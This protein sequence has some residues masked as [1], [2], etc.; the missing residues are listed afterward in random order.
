MR[1][2]AA[3][4]DLRAALSDEIRAAL[5][6]VSVE[7]VKPKAVHRCR[8]RLKRARALARVGR[9]CAPGLAAVFNESARAIMIS[10][11]QARDLA[12]L[13]ACARTTA[14]KAS[15]KQAAALTA[16]ADI[17]DA[18][19]LASPP[20]NVSD[21]RT[22]LRDLLAMA[23]V[24]PEASPRQVQR[25]A[26]RIARRARA[27]RHQGRGSA[28]AADRHE[29]RKREK[30]RLYAVELLGSSWP[31]QRK[32]RRKKSQ[33][34]GEI[35]GQERDALLLVDRLVEQP[36]LAGDVCDAS[37]ARRALKRRLNHLAQRADAMGERLHCGGA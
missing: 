2:P 29:W 32:R 37:R 14:K 23:Q 30:D 11:A 19:S 33:A 6:A 22:G 34:L 31:Q 36:V 16:T 4:F 9:A 25:G 17:L 8:V 18:A 28:L 3:A 27:A 20:P 1:S 7:P 12:A 21:I 35:L 15:K 10:L 13:A 5:D 24:W 26:E